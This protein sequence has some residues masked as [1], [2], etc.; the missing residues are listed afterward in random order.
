[1]DIHRS[2]QPVENFMVRSGHYSDI[3]LAVAFKT[4]CE[5]SGKI[6]IKKELII[7]YNYS[8]SSYHTI[9]IIFPHAIE[10]LALYIT[11]HGPAVPNQ[12]LLKS[13]SLFI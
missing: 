12:L 6:H 10:L 11:N 9:M 13:T 4:E 8:L 7:M 3:L 5:A 2:S 1:M